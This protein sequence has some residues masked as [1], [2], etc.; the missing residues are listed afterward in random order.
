MQRYFLNTFVYMFK[1]LLFLF[2]F[3]SITTF[4]QDFVE[5]KGKILGG[6][7]SKI[8]YGAVIF[9]KT[10]LLGTLSNRIGNFKMR[11]KPGD[12]LEISHISFYTQYIIINNPESFVENVLVINLQFRSYELPTIDV[13]KYRIRQKA[14]PPP[15]MRRTD[16]ITYDMGTI[17]LGVGENYYNYNQN[18]NLNN[19]G[20]PNFMP[21]FGVPI[22]DWAANRRKE[23]FD[24]IAKLEAQRIYE[25]RIQIRYNRELVRSLTGLKG[26]ELEQFMGF[27]KIP[28]KIALAGNEYELT[29]AVLKCY[30]NFKI[31]FDE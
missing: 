24:K 23:Q 3:V 14:I 22:G 11:A 7:S 28:E 15:T 30:E 17:R 19:G 25:K 20:I 18:Q 21:I 13:T 6:D 31:E 26:N 12:T 16:N 5:I 1:R 9:N 27:C 2:L 4:S 10:R 8:I 29:N